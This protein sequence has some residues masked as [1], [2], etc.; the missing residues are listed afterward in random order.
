MKPLFYAVPLLALLCLRTLLPAG[1]VYYAN[2]FLNNG[3]S[4]RAAGMG[5]AMAAD[6]ADRTAG[7]YN[8]CGLL[9]LGKATF[10]IS[11]AKLF[12]ADQTLNLASAAFPLGPSRAVGVY[13]LRSAVDGIMNTQGFATDNAGAPVYSS[14]NLTYVDNADY[15][16]GLSYAASAGNRL[17][18]G[19]TLKVLRR[20]LY[21]LTGYGIGLDAGAQYRVTPEFTLGLTGKNLTTTATRYFADDWEVSLPELYAGVVYKMDAEYIYGSIEFAYQAGNLLSTSGVSQGAFGG[22]A[23]MDNAAPGETGLLKD[24]LGYFT[25]GNF[26]VEYTM[27]RK[28]FFRL[29]TN[30]QY[31][32]TMG[33][34]IK[35]KNLNVDFAFLHHLQ[36]D[37]SY[38]FSLAWDL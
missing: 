29:G 11:H 5:E 20:R 6:P 10:L 4:P 32:Y 8:P 25:R 2:E 26:G 13:L 23:D 38:R 22:T 33:A 17:N 1:V 19:A 16:M 15:A 36:M 18:Y 3:G 28:L 31:A 30:A 12:D 35:I 9:G 37:D 34:G 24:P 14:A 21:D 27:R 7:Y